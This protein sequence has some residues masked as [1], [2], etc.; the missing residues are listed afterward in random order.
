MVVACQ[1]LQG[2]QQGYSSGSEYQRCMG[3]GLGRTRKGPHPTT[4][5]GHGWMDG[6]AVPEPGTMHQHSA[7]AVTSHQHFP[8]QISALPMLPLGFG[9]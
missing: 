1:E 8:F 2:Q 5:A 7:V 6:W 9:Q 3:G 4:R